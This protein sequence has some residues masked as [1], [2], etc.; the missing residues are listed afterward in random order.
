MCFF[1][2]TIVQINAF[3]YMVHLVVHLAAVSTNPA[4]SQVLKKL[5]Q[6]GRGVATFDR[7]QHRHVIENLFCYICM[8]N[9]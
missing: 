3:L 7:A 1:S 9:V 5:K 2:L 4:D 6:Q 8:V